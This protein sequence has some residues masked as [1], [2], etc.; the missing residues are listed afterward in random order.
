MQKL[1]GPRIVP[2]AGR[3]NALVVLLHGYGADGTDLISLAHQWQPVL[4][5]AAF[6]APNAPEPL[7]MAAGMGGLQWFPLTLRDPSEYWRGANEAGPALDAFLDEELRRHD[8]PANRLALVGFSQGTMMALH[9]GV[10]RG[11]PPAAIV[12][13][14]G[15]VAGFEHVPESV[16]EHPAIMLVHGEA[17]EVV[18]VD[19]LDMTREALASRG[20]LVEW[21]R[22]P[23]LAHGIDPVGLALG[24][25]FLARCLG[26]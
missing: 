25:H 10:R 23:D 4:G 14:S 24:G 12:G 15:T 1:D 21:H 17:D 13:Y 7:P 26:R 20:H 9:V 16:G 19:A 3:P 2:K 22:R 18:P 6:V 5:Q 11:V 8:L